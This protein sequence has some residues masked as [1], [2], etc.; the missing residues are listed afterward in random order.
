MKGTLLLDGVVSQ[1]AAVLE[2]LPGK[3]QPLLIRW[4]ALLVLD[5]ALDRS[6]RI[7]GLRLEGDVLSSERLDKNLHRSSNMYLSFSRFRVRWFVAIFPPTS[8]LISPFCH[9]P[10]SHYPRNRQFSLEIPAFAKKAFFL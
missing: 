5:T 7:A 9:P 1:G 4:D 10:V 3:D 8:L 6:D 2:L